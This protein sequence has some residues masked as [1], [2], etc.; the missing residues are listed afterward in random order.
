MEISR[1]DVNS[2]ALTEY[3]EKERFIKIPIENYLKLIDIEPVP[4][5][6]AVIN[7]IQNPK[8]RFIVGVLAR[9]TGKSFI[10][11]VIGHLTTLIPGSNILVIAPNYSLSSISW[12]LQR[13]LL[14][15]FEVELDRSNAKDK[16]IELKNGSTIR[17]G[18]IGQVDSVVGR[19][20]DL[21]IFDE[22]ALNNDGEKAFNIQLRPTLDKPNSKALFISTP[23][24][25]NFLYDFYKRGFRDDF[26]TWCSI[27]STCY[28][29]PRANPQD[30]EDA[31]KSMSD[32][33]FRQEFLGDFVANQGQVWQIRKENIVDV[34]LEKLDILDVIAGMDMGFRDKTAIVVLATDGHDWYAVAEYLQN[35]RSTSKYAEELQ[36]LI[37]KW[38]LDFIYID[39]AAQQTRYDLAYDYDI[40]TINAKKALL[41]GIGYCSSI[42][43]HDRLFVDK[44][45]TNLID[46]LDNYQWDN[47]EGLLNERPRHNEYSH[48]AD[49]LRYA[50]YSHAY[51]VDTIGS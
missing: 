12:D 46:C 28:D 20:Y 1:E 18:S 10:S 15:T 24:G 29:N 41:D 27:H 19:S 44:S 43:E 39:S 23:R 7:A 47:K 51:N 33:E 11:N 49:A 45:C 9:R 35:E 38:N 42:I 48:M 17:M 16:I 3:T 32:A 14:N 36:K 25:K 31:R 4:P 40:T 13:K 26:P 21:I 50:L 34:D 37:D 5:Q 8:Y 30:I 6:I 22:A 2:T